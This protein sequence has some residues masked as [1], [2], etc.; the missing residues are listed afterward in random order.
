MRTCGGGWWSRHA[1]GKY[2]RPGRHAAS[3]PSAGVARVHA[4]RYSRHLAVVL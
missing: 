1:R 2:E 3:K 4:V